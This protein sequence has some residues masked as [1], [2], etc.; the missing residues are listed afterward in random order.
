[1]TNDFVWTISIIAQ[2]DDFSAWEYNNLRKSI[3]WQD[4][5]ENLRYVIFDY[6]QKER[7]A[8][9]WELT[10]DY[11]TLRLLDTKENVSLT[12]PATLTDFFDNYV[13]ANNG[14]SKHHMLITWGHG[15]GLGYFYYKEN[16][17]TKTKNYIPYGI[18]E[19]TPEFKQWEK[20]LN[21]R[22]SN[23]NHAIANLS[24][25]RN[26]INY[27]NQINDIRYFKNDP[28]YY[29]KD[30]NNQKKIK[31]RTQELLTA[32]ELAEILE[33]S[34]VEKKIDVY[35]ANNCWTNMFEVGYALRKQVDM[36]VASQSIVPFAGIDY[37]K[38]FEH[39]EKNPDL[40]L[41]DDIDRRKLA[42][43]IT[44]SFLPRY[45][46]GSFAAAFKDLRPDLNP[47]HFT[48]SVNSLKYYEDLFNVINDLSDYL[49]K[50]LERNKVEYMKRID[51]A[52]NFCGD[53][54]QGVG[55]IDFTN[56]FS[57][58]IKGFQGDNPGQLKNIYK[59][60][61][62]LKDKTLLSI[63][64]PGDLFR[65]MPNDFYSQSPQM[66]SIFFPSKFKRSHVIDELLDLYFKDITS[67]SIWQNWS[68]PKF[69]DAYWGR[70]I[71][72]KQK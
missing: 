71:L 47:R 16:V 56:F 68:W 64:N 60:F 63:L 5:V 39:L 4:K 36:Y 11:Q 13:L 15:S 42:L 19:D 30:T 65:L 58:L 12:E 9:F 55:Y 54:A 17:D 70:N 18:E 6:R 69:L 34:F 43:K 38:L 33:K 20:G 32:A 21:R 53:F 59:D 10:K 48:I 67:N 41:K 46:E 24:P 66:F 29:F 2:V 44:D 50:K 49:I 51:I 23:L 26:S 27:V 45:T 1:M 57:E 62:F 40:N 7:K 37:G 3:E 25:G 31:D 61:F 72:S 52:R 35:I 14:S 8:I 28:S 22:N